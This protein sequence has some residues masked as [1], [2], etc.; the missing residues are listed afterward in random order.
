MRRC[1]HRHSTGS[2]EVV[3]SATQRHGHSVR[4]RRIGAAAPHAVCRRLK[5]ETRVEWE[6]NVLPLRVPL[7]MDEDEVGEVRHANC[8][9]LC[10]STYV[11]RLPQASL[12]SLVNTFKD[13]IMTIYNALLCE[14]VSA[15]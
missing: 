14:K 3:R 10:S 4:E 15:S 7:A 5:Y 11:T 2:R 6:G 9:A 8:A 13:G 12:T 1:H